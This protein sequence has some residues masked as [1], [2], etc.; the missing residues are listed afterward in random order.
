MNVTTSNSVLV[1]VRF[2]GCA[3]AA[4]LAVLFLPL[5]AASATLDWPADRLLPA[6]PKPATLIDCIRVR[7]ASGPEVDLF[8]SLEGIINRVQPRIACSGGRSDDAAEWLEIHHLQYQVVDGFAVVEKYKNE[9]NGLI[10]VDPGQPETANVAT[11]LAGLDSSLICYPGLLARLTN[12]PYNF[13][14]KEDLRGKFSSRGEVYD[15]FLKTVWPRCDHRIIAGLSPRVHGS[16]RDFL[17]AANAAV[18]WLDPK[19]Q[20]DAAQL[21]KFTPELRPGHA[22]YMGWWPDEDAGLKWIGAYGIPVLAS[23]FFQNASLLGGVVVKIQ[24]PPVPPPP[25]LQNKIYLAMYISDGDNV[26][27][28]QHYMKKLWS[29]S[30]RGS[31]PIGWTVSPL[32]VDLDPAMLQYYYR[33]A[34]TNDCLVSGPSGAGYARLDF[35]KPEH[36]DIF[37][38]ATNPYLERSGIGIITVW[39]NVTDEIGNAFGANCPALLGITS[40]GGGSREKVYE[41]LPLIGFVAHDAYADTTEQLRAGMEKA[42]KS[43]DGKSPMFVAV[44]A[45]AWKITPA[46]LKKQGDSLDLAKFALVRPDHLFQL[47]NTWR[48]SAPATSK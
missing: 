46:D 37:T 33:T 35:W 24:P 44:Q 17:V 23:D 12:A 25:P 40:Q 30:A 16:L 27:Y 14:I 36:L 13:K 6:F 4:L 21:E 2:P 31:V 19:N 5:V 18:V 42:E 28:M 29:D 38:K 22:L 32:S 9:I 8:S 20:E 45:N 7:T 47:Y 1:W 11:T 48:Q 15:Y 39:M 34:T 10:V 41:K 26:Q 3:I 43:W